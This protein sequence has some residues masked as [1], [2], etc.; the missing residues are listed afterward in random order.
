MRGGF[1][2]E[3]SGLRAKRRAANASLFACAGLALA[4]I[5]AATQGPVFAHEQ[6]AAITRVLFNP[7]THNIEVMHRFLL[8]DAEH[9]VKLIFG[10]TADI[11]EDDATRGRFAD[12]VYRRFSLARADETPITL[13]PV[14]FEIDGRYLWVYQEAPAPASLDM[15]TIRHDA[16]RDIW[17]DQI[18]LVN[19]ERGEVLRTA[20]FHGPATALT[21]NLSAD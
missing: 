21:V 17:P 3:M 10:G 6:K 1:M 16:L 2:R 7:R 19:V 20:T 4:S 11:L 9:A 14:G 13:T 15:L 18:N 8:H 5:V 12:Y